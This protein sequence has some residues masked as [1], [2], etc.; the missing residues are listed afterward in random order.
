MK[1]SLNS[2]EKGNTING[3]GWML[4]MGLQDKII[5]Q[6]TEKLNMDD[7]RETLSGL[8]DKIVAMI[9]HEFFDRI[10]IQKLAAELKDDIAAQISDKVI[11]LLMESLKK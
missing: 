10:D 5:K 6:I 2:F 9:G 1:N 4:T 8:D 3:F 11:N 7:I